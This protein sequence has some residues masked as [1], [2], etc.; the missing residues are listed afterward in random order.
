MMWIAASAQSRKIV[1]VSLKTIV[2]GLLAGISFPLLQAQRM[3]AQ[4][5]CFTDGPLITT[6]LS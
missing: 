4:Y 3:C 2:H 1:L 5:G 6:R